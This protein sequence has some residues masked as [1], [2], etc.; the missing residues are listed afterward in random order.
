MT[1]TQ[2]VEIPAIRRI[3]NSSP[4]PKKK[5]TNKKTKKIL[6]KK[7][8]L[9]KNP[10]KSIQ[11][12]VPLGFPAGRTILTFTPAP[13]VF[14]AADAEVRDVELINRNAERLNR[15]ALEGLSFQSLEI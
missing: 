7:P 12:N 13:V 14:P 3:T 1:I 4:P 2:T 9:Q 15:E 8:I 10:K 6:Q 5:P 11:K